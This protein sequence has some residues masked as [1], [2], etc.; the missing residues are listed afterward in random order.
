M[1]KH[2]DSGQDIVSVQKR[3]QAYCEA[4]MPYGVYHVNYEGWEEMPVPISQSGYTDTVAF[5]GSCKRSEAMAS[6]M[7][8]MLN[9]KKNM[10]GSY[11]PSAFTQ[12]DPGRWGFTFPDSYGF[13]VKG[14][15]WSGLSK[16]WRAMC[17][18]NETAA[19][20]TIKLNFSR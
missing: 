7:T 8:T 1:L 18:Y 12:A 20:T 10:Y 6:M 5:I 16:S 4:L 13:A 11:M 19:T 9:N 2:G 3:C 14:A 17:K 15:Q